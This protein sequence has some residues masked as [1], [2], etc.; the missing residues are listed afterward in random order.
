MFLSFESLIKQPNNDSKIVKKSKKSKKNN[1]TPQNY[2][3][4][5]IDP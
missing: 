2:E 3:F 4:H 5:K 1:Q